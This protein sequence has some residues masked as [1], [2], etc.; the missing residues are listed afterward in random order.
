MAKS[1]TAFQREIDDVLTEQFNNVSTVREFLLKKIAFLTQ[2]LEESFGDDVRVFIKGGSSLN[3]M[4]K[5]RSGVEPSKWSDFDNQ[6]VIN[7]NLP[8]YRWYQVFSEVHNYLKEEYMPRF[9]QDWE[10]FLTCNRKEL[11]EY[12]QKGLQLFKG[13]L[14]DNKVFD[15]PTLVFSV[16]ENGSVSASQQK[17]NKEALP[18]DSNSKDEV[19]TSKQDGKKPL[20]SDSNLKDEVTTSKQNGKKEVVSE[21]EEALEKHPLNLTLI[22]GYQSNMI[23][24]SGTVLLHPLNHFDNAMLL[25]EVSDD[26]GLVLKK[27]ELH[28]DDIFYNSF[29][30]PAPM[31]LDATLNANENP[32]SSSILVNNSISKFVLYRV[33]VRYVTDEYSSDGEPRLAAGDD[34]KLGS[35]HKMFGPTLAKFR[36]ELLDV[37]IPR[38]DCYETIQQWAQVRTMPVQYKEAPDHSSTWLNVPDWRYQLNE[39]VLLILEV[40][41]EISGSPHKFYKRVL[42]GCNAVEAINE[43]YKERYSD[44]SNEF[45]ALAES[46][47]IT[48]FKK[49]FNTLSDHKTLGFLRPLVK[50]LFD[51]VQKDY[52]WKNLASSLAKFKMDNAVDVEAIIGGDI[53]KSLKDNWLILQNEKPDKSS[54]KTYDDILIKEVKNKDDKRSQV[55]RDADYEKAKM[56][57][58]FMRFYQNIHQEF[59]NK[60]MFL[61]KPTSPYDINFLNDFRLELEK[62]PEVDQSIMSGLLSSMVHTKVMTGLSVFDYHLPY[63]ELFVIMDEKDKLKKLQHALKGISRIDVIG[64]VVDADETDY[65]VIPSVTVKLRG[66]ALPVVI[67][68]LDAVDSKMA[69]ITGDN[70]EQV[71]VELA[72]CLKEVRLKISGVRR[73]LSSL[74]DLEHSVISMDKAIENKNQN[75]K[76][77]VSLKS[78]LKKDLASHTKAAQSLIKQTD[79]NSYKKQLHYSFNPFSS[80]CFIR[81]DGSEF[82]I[83]LAAEAVKHMEMMLT[84]TESYYQTHWLDHHR[85][86]FK[87]C[88]TSFPAKRIDLAKS[89]IDIYSSL[90]EYKPKLNFSAIAKSDFSKPL[91]YEVTDAEQ[92]VAQIRARYSWANVGGD[93]APLLMS[94]LLQFPIEV[95]SAGSPEDIPVGRLTQIHAFNQRLDVNFNLAPMH[96]NGFNLTLANIGQQ[97]TNA[98]DCIRI[99]KIGNHYWIRDANGGLVDTDRDGDCFFSAVMSYIDNSPQLTVQNLRTALADYAETLRNTLYQGTNRLQYIIDNIGALENSFRPNVGYHEVALNDVAALHRGIIRNLKGYLIVGAGNRTDDQDRSTL[100]EILR[101]ANAIQDWTQRR[102]DLI[103]QARAFV[104]TGGRPLAIALP[105]DI[106]LGI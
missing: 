74:F 86:E 50:D 42:R 43:S 13:D 34:F 47:S 15:F 14:I 8:I 71:E 35:D 72:E 3:I 60:L 92:V 4:K 37:S 68:V 79:R 52:G 64:S 44:N 20:S 22:K 77:N 63:V 19:T 28:Q 76:D 32:Y 21:S 6:I 101:D 87:Q 94:Q 95:A 84:F 17:Q 45:K 29:F 36:G 18:T 24:N 97:L 106:D 61:D 91:Q 103:A 26:V 66:F 62:K 100:H 5:A 38:R 69:L 31:P 56:M 96:L 83:L 81:N 67:R 12:Q 49:A 33:I 54:A 10:A 93:I 58:G 40:F 23:F 70:L 105:S 2:H 57:L 11:D 90:F 48:N 82:R 80:V 25:P 88:V 99:A 78:R 51:T 65:K 9:Q 73:Q 39:N 85:I 59:A 53:E 7:P 41:N 55:E 89:N 27:Q 75:S 16:K 1:R 46:I 98:T 102:L 104:T 30:P